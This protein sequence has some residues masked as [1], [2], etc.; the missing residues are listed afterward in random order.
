[1]ARFKEFPDCEAIAAAALRAAAIAGVGSRVYSSV[2]KEPAFPLIVVR[3]IGGAPAVREY[4]DA[5][6]LQV[7]VWGDSKSGARDAAARARVVLL[8]LE[9]TSVSSPV[10]AWVSAVED[11]LGLT[12]QPDPETGRDRYLFG[13]TLIA[14]TP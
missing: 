9:G 4:M 13:V 6:N 8:E 1:M 12:W 14:R 10:A 5:A 3:R 11:S 7:D 2:P